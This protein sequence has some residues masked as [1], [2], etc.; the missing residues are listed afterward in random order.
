MK[1]NQ[2]N[3]LS[4]IRNEKGF[5]QETLSGLSGVTVRTIQ[6]IEAGDVIPQHQTLKLIADVLGVEPNDIVVGVAPE[7]S[8]TNELKTD[9]LLLYHALPLLGIILPFTNVILPLILWIVKRDVH[10]RFD[11][12]GRAAVN[13]QLT[14]TLAACLS[15]P[16][17]VFYMPVGFFLLIASYATG[18]LVC[19]RNLI[20]VLGNEQP[21]YPFA[22]PFIKNPANVG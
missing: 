19:I 12:D 2:N 15:I 3:N 14:I 21:K 6:R 4:R 22:I 8:G 5:T 1:K 13:F 20:R 17:L 11:I 10:P 9:F 18:I 7:K 16:V